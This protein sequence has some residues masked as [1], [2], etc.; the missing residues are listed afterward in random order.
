MIPQ[1]RSTVVTMIPVNQFMPAAVARI[2]RKAPLSPEKVAFAWRSAVGAAVDKVTSIELRGGVL[3]VQAKDATWQREIERSAAV[4][5]GRLDTLLGSGVVRY[6]EVT[7][8]AAAAPASA[9]PATAAQPAQVS[10]AEAQA[11]STGPSA[12]GSDSARRRR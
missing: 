4:I 1:R 12:G 9:G 2:L 7:A 6:V 10:G 8:G 11:R 5:R 3:R